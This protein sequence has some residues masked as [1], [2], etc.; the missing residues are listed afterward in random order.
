MEV[1]FFCTVRV[2][3]R[4]S[5]TVENRN[6]LKFLLTYEFLGLLTYVSAQTEDPGVGF[7]IACAIGL[8]NIPEGFAVAMPIYIGTNS[9]TKAMFYG[10]FSFFPK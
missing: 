10:E 4:E 3:D 6:F 8:H 1:S 7:G 9:R 2:L 5:I